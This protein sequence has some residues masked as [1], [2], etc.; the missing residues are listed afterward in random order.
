[1]R[2]EE[3]GGSRPRLMSTASWH[4][5]KMSWEAA[6][7]VSSTGC[8]DRGQ[9]LCWVSWLL[10][11]HLRWWRQ[12][13]L[14]LSLCSVACLAHTSHS[15]TSWK[16]KQGVSRGAWWGHFPNTHTDSKSGQPH[17]VDIEWTAL[18][19]DQECFGGPWCPCCTL[20]VTHTSWVLSHPH[21]W[22]GK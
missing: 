7:L 9:K 22:W 16:N 8:S 14:T 3:L 6:W 5:N 2:S 10:A 17:V 1:M 19:H 11:H 20:W 12:Q 21:L 15:M 4:P 18:G 13:L